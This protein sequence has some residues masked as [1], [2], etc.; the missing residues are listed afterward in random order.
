MQ[1]APSPHG[2]MRRLWRRKGWNSHQLGPAIRPIALPVAET[3]SR[4]FV[5][6]CEAMKG[7]GVFDV[8]GPKGA[9]VR[10]TRN[11][12]HAGWRR[13]AQPRQK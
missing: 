11:V 9:K 10:T 13:V 12:D 3:P 5:R 1:R 8:G 4:I 2:I 6:F 7:V